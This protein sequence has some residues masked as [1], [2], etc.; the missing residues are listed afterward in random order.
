MIVNPVLRGFHPDPC[1]CRAEGKYYLITSTFE[2]LPGVSLYES[3]DL[4]HWKA[5]GGLLEGLNLRGIPDSAGVWAPA[6][7]YDNGLFYLVYTISRQIDGSF[8]DV[9]NYVVTARRIE[10]PWS[11]PVFINASGFDPSMFHENGRHYVL[12]PQWDSRLLPGHRKFNGLLLQEFDM[13]KGMIGEA[14]VVFSGSSTGGT[15]GPHLMKKDGFYYIIAAE[16][17]TGRHH[18]ICVARSEKLWGPYEISP[19]HPLITSWEKDTILKKS[20][21]GNFVETPD[22]EWY[23][24]HLC[25]RYL[26][27]KDVCVLER[28]SPAE[29]GMDRWMAQ[30]G[31]GELCTSCGGGSACE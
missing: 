6:L 21:H 27:R 20:G 30:N 8:K 19:Y 15:E 14:K 5:R 29:A 26:D 16:G 10:G 24:T 9:E 31:S 7:S 17:G 12:N 11:E 18:S 28:D 23:M 1:I 25:A 13:E 4:V 22:G 3:E 2:W